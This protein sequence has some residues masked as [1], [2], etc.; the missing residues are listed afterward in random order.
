MKW[1]LVRIGEV[2]IGE[3]GIGE[4]GIDGVGIGRVGIGGVG[5]GEVKVGEAV[6]QWSGVCQIRWCSDLVHSLLIDSSEV[7]GMWNILVSKG[8][9]QRSREL[10]CEVPDTVP[11]LRGLCTQL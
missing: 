5:I 2:G 6:V 1:G 7:K 9:E 4:V 11:N 8:G 10:Q 3:A